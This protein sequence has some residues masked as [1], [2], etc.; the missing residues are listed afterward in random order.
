[1]F[2]K[3]GVLKNFAI[4]NRKAKNSFF[5]TPPVAAFGGTKICTTLSFAL[6]KIFIEILYSMVNIWIRIICGK[7][8]QYI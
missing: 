5:R 8:K 2:F 7:C 3:T 1:M 4:F 6:E